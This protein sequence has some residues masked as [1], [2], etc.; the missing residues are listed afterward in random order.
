MQQG[1]V[2]GF[3][4]HLGHSCATYTDNLSFFYKKVKA[5]ASSGKP[6]EQGWATL[7]L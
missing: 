5:S 3:K 4:T 6:L 7:A 2:Y 1:G